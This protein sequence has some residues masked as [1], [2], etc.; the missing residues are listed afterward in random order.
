MGK[1]PRKPTRTNDPG[2]QDF[3]RA[4]KQARE[5]TQTIHRRGPQLNR[6]PK[7]G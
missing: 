3:S 2:H 7:E 1:R 5:K 6:E 4:K